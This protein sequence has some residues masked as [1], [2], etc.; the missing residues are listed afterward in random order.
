MSAV[1]EVRGLRKSFD[2]FTA[3]AGIDLALPEGGITAVIGPN[4]AGKTTFINLLSG[5][6]VPDE[7]R[8]VF[9]GA[10]VTRLPPSAR[11][12]VGMAR[13]FQITNV[14]PLLSVEENVAVPVLARAGLSL[15]PR[16][17]VDAIGEAHAQVRSAAQAGDREGTAVDLQDGDVV[18]GVGADDLGRQ[19]T[20]AVD[21]DL[22]RIGAVDHVEVG[23]DVPVAAEQHA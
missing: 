11:V 5:K 13:T 3:V 6:L 4:G 1:L 20:T 2:D 16:R 12:R 14:F 23:E 18:L 9:A 21:D 22:H 17:R 15:E 10:D 19:L 8:V 7:G